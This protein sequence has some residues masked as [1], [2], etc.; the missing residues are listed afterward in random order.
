MEKTTVTIEIKQEVSIALIWIAAG[1]VAVSLAFFLT[2]RSPELWPALD[3]AGVA[4]GVYLIA[5]LAYTLRKPLSTQL[6]VLVG[7][8]AL[9]ALSCTVLAWQSKEDQSHL[10][11]ERVAHI[12]VIVAR[13][14]LY[15]EMSIPLLNTLGA[16]HQQGVGKHETLA[17]VFRRLHKDAVVGFNVHKPSWKGDPMKVIVKSLD[18]DRIVLV[19]QET[20]VE[21]RDLHFKNY[22]GKSGMVQEEFILTEKGITHVSEN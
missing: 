22:D 15:S 18:P 14:L 21:G 16:Y 4:A 1:V 2:P 17:D 6:R 19:S 13:Q 3:A 10:Q 11:A 12:R 5:L 7:G 9:I 20:S 8:I